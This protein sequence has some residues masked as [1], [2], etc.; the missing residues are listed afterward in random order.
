MDHVG[1]YEA[2]THFSALWKRVEVLPDGLV[3]RHVYVIAAR[4]D[5]AVPST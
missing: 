5:D 3:S 1:A 2:R 4:T